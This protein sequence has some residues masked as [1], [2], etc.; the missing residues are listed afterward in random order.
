MCIYIDYISNIAHLSSEYQ[1][2]I[3]E[4][5]AYLRNHY[6]TNVFANIKRIAKEANYLLPTCI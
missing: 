4:K 1:N 6:I 3:T 5:I 2:N